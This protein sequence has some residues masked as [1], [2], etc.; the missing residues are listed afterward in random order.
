VVEI[1]VKDGGALIERCPGD[2]D[3]FTYIF[4]SLEDVICELV[5]LT[6]EL[7]DKMKVRSRRYR[8]SSHISGH[9]RPGS[10]FSVIDSFIK[11]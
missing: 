8:G 11:V 2:S 5:D 6:E 1:I 7:N 10:S 9:E 3:A 4:L